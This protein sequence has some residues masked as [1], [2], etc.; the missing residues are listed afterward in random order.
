MVGATPYY[1]SGTYTKFGGLLNGK[2]QYRYTGGAAPAYLYFVNGGTITSG[3]WVITV[4]GVPI[5]D[6]GWVNKGN[7]ATNNPYE[8]AVVGPTYFGSCAADPIASNQPILVTS[9]EYSTVT[10]QD[11]TNIA[12][13]EAALV[14]T[15]YAVPLDGGTMRGNVYTAGTSTFVKVT[16]PYYTGVTNTDLL[17]VSGQMYV[18]LQWYTGQYSKVGV[19]SYTG[20]HGGSFTYTKVYISNS[21]G[22]LETM[23]FIGFRVDWTNNIDAVTG[24]Y[25]EIGGVKS[26]SID[27]T[28]IITELTT[29][30]YITELDIDHT[31]LWLHVNNPTVT[32]G[33]GATSEV[34]GVAIGS[35][36]LVET[37][38]G[39]AIGKSSAASDGITIGKNTAV[40]ALRSI[41]IG[42]DT[43]TY[44]DAVNM[45]Q[46]GYAGADCVN[47][48]TGGRA[49]DNS[50]SVGK[51]ALATAEGVAVGQYAKAFAGAAI[52]FGVTNQIPYTMAIQTGTPVN[53][54]HVVTLGWH[55]ERLPYACNVYFTNVTRAYD[56]GTLLTNMVVS[57]WQ[58]SSITNGCNW[59]ANGVTV[60]KS[61]WWFVSASISLDNDNDSEELNTF[62]CTNR[63]PLWQSWTH[64]AM[65]GNSRAVVPMNGVLYIPSGTVMSVEVK[66]RDL[67]SISEGSLAI[68]KL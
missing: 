8:P 23:N 27:Y 21:V 31:S 18:G 30:E 29:N 11:I 13:L 68:H 26:G 2:P 53:A 67:D 4:L 5:Y 47:V 49:T 3:K 10:Y 42:E 1:F 59:T 48:G 34:N 40:Y 43:F 22:W 36:A 38:E 46:A 17:Q 50:V 54:N 19:N 20:T 33:R 16:A 56:G 57:P 45:G 51:G 28:R 39:I 61:G 6:S 55:D 7:N 66:I 65:F 14:V 15:Q 62:V 12:L 60:L 24:H 64:S 52:G 25:A 58:Y 63:V 35:N 9:S 44:I 32:H 37:T 41:G